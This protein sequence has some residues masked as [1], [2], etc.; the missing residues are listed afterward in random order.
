MSDLPAEALQAGAEVLHDEGCSDGDTKTCGRWNS[1]VPGGYDPQRHIGYYKDR[2]REVLEAALPHLATALSPSLL[3]SMAEDAIIAVQQI[4]D[5]E[6]ERA[7]L[8]V[9][10][11][12]DGEQVA[13]VT[14]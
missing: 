2:A 10:S 6:K 9:L 5:E 4:G 14:Q 13:E 3:R 1:N 12:L 11:A 8:S 7:Y